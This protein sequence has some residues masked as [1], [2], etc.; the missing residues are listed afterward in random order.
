[1][2]GVRPSTHAEAETAAV[3]GEADGDAE[4]EME[5]ESESESGL[6]SEARSEMLLELKAGASNRNRFGPF[7]AAANVMPYNIQTDPMHHMGNPFI[8]GF[9][10]AFDGWS[11][12]TGGHEWNNPNGPYWSPFHWTAPESY[13]SVYPPQYASHYVDGPSS[14]GGHPQHAG[15]YSSWDQFPYRA[16]HGAP[17]PHVFGP[18]LDWPF[19]AYT[20]DINHL[21]GM[22]AGKNDK[23]PFPQ[24]L[25]TSATAEAEAEAEADAHAE[26]TADAVAD[27]ADADAARHAFHAD[28][29]E[30][31][32]ESDS[33]AA[34]EGSDFAVDG[35]N[36]VVPLRQACVNCAFRD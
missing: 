23:L 32:S 35:G 24:F 12:Q 14:F 1:M 29:D 10:P 25:Q 19:G 11:P 26:L 6:E 7:Q 5:S 13:W 4:S 9:N 15:M 33:L 18:H 17:D 28:E 27:A 2:V 31:E 36:K 22:G 16:A 30:L 34:E 3:T 8:R 21:P 20:A